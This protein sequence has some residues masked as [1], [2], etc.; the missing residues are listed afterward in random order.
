MSIK[1][2]H[3]VLGVKMSQLREQS[4][5]IVSVIQCSVKVKPEEFKDWV[6]NRSSKYIF[7]LKEEKLVSYEWH[8]SDD[9]TEAT[10]VELLADSDGYMQRIKNHLESP[11]AGEVMELVDFKGWLVFGNAKPDLVEALSPFGAK[12]QNYFFGFNHSL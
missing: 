9:E 11:I 4:N 2:K 6:K 7:N 8:L 3:S 5:Q 12:F 10:L 1:N